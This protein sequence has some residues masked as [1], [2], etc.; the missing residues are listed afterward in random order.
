MPEKYV[1]RTNFWENLTPLD[2]SHLKVFLEFFWEVF[3]FLNSNLNFKF[4]PVG[5]RPEPVWPDRFPTVFLTLLQTRWILLGVR[6]T[7]SDSVCLLAILL[8]L[9]VFC[10]SGNSEL[11]ISFKKISELIK[12]L[13][14]RFGI[15]KGVGLVALCLI[16]AL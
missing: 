4:G 9:L 10:T 2:S 11:I 13:V 15:S 12:A 14:L 1:K 5:Y 7:V 16:K 6:V 8:L 3:I